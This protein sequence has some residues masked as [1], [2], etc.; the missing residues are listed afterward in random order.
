VSVVAGMVVETVPGAA[1]E[2]AGRLARVPGLSLAGGDGQSRIAVVCEAADGRALEEL[3][4]RLLAGDEQ[5]LGIFPT[6]VGDDE[7][8]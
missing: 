1:A 7:E 2:V 4:E 5:V 3:S 8:G 6:F